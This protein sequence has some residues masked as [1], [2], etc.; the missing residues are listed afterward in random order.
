MSALTLFREGHGRLYIN[1]RE[2]S[3]VYSR[4]LHLPDLPSG[5]SEVAVTLHA[6]DY[7]MYAVD[8]L[9][10]QASTRVTTPS[11]QVVDLDLQADDKKHTPKKIQ[12]NRGDWVELRW[13]S[14]RPVALHLHGYDLEERSEPEPDGR[15]RFKADIEGR[16]AL[17][18]H[19][20][21]NHATAANPEEI[22][23]YVEV[24]PS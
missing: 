2:V 7:R 11:M 13:R 19:A 9:P 4:W 10:L 12:A 23:S 17:E 20:T 5:D 8:G 15:L 6:N 3:R 14:D 24:Y 1:G 22:V 16:F 18:N 21:E